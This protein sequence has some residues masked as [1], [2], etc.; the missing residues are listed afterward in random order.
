MD[1]LGFMDWI[2]DLFIDHGAKLFRVKGVVRFKGV[3]ERSAIQ[4]VR[5]HVEVVRMSSEG[6]LDEDCVEMRSRLVFIG[7]ISGL[8]A[9]IKEDFAGLGQL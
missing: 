8:E 5:S 7:Q 9:Q 6:T 2:Q 1:E 3:K 4:C